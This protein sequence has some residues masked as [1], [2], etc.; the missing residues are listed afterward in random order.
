MLDDS[1][2]L[3]PA[4]LTISLGKRVQCCGPSLWE[5]VEGS[6]GEDWSR[7]LDGALHNKFG[8]RISLDAGYGIDLRKDAKEE[9]S[10]EESY[11]VA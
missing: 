7:I 8:S 11:F 1:E 9:P 5:G 6:C 4:R 10:L 3:R 2:E